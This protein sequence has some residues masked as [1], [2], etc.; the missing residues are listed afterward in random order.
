MS[1]RHERDSSMR[2][3]TRLQRIAVMLAPLP[4]SSDL[5]A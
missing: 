1:I 5:P 4:R 2:Q 3:S